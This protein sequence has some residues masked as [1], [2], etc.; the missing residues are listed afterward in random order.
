MVV[1][2]I[3]QPVSLLSLFEALKLR[4]FKTRKYVKITLQGLTTNGSSSRR[5][6]NKSCFVIL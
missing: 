6:A 3:P 1:T 5:P 4:R 2:L